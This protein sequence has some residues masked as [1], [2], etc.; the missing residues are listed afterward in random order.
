MNL[1]S[2]DFCGFF[3]VAPKM[4]VGCPNHHL[5][6]WAPG[7]VTWG[8]DLG[9]RSQV[10]KVPIAS[11]IFGP[12]RMVDAPGTFDGSRVVERSGKN[13]H[14]WKINMSPSKPTKGQFQ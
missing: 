14:H 1:W 6:P 4:W 7:L 2:L 8:W 10:V 12:L 13:V 5:P 11:K 3:F 9:L